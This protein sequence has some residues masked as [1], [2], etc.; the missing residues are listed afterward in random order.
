MSV[1]VRC[2]RTCVF[3]FCLTP[4]LGSPGYSVDAGLPKPAQLAPAN[5]LLNSGTNGGYT[6][7]PPKQGGGT[8]HLDP[9]SGCVEGAPP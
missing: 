6:G 3:I 4:T 2:V 5:H 1:G 7:L 9:Q 8:P